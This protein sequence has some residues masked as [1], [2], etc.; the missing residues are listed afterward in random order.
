MKWGYLYYQPY[1]SMILDGMS[2]NGVYH[3]T[4][5]ILAVL[6]GKNVDQASNLGMPDFPEP[7][8]RQ[9]SWLV[10][11]PPACQLWSCKR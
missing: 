8:W 5:P 6:M 7:K 2:K 1:D 4:P 9:S 11:P 3:D 10:L